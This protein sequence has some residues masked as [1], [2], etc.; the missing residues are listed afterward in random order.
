MASFFETVEFDPEASCSSDVTQIEQMIDLLRPVNSSCEMLR[1][2]GSGD[3]AYLVPALV[4]DMTAC[5]SPGTASY[6]T[7]ED[8][9]ANLYGI[10]SFMIDGSVDPSLLS[11]SL[12]YNYQSFQK[13]WLEPITIPGLSICLSDWMA[14]IVKSGISLEKSILQMD[15]EGAEY[16]NIMSWS[17]DDLKSFSIL[18][19]ELHGLYSARHRIVLEECIM[20]VLSRLAQYYEVLHIHPNNNSYNGRIHGYAVPDVLEVTLIRKSYALSKG[21]IFNSYPPSL[22]HVLDIVNNPA[23]K[24]VYIDRRWFN[25]AYQLS[26]DSLEVKINQLQSYYERKVA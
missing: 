5:L 22:P 13:I 11:T 19:L 25:E 21:V 23:K 1:L 12:I 9:L 8:E 6:K 10:R 24:P 14:S 7:F 18:I 15:I 2:G 20:P 26:A 4:S 3:G 16:K 17:D